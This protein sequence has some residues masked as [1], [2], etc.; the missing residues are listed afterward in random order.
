MQ[1]PEEIAA[2]LK[3][4]AI[5]NSKPLQGSWEDSNKVERTI[6]KNVCAILQAGSGIQVGRK[7]SEGV[8]WF[9]ITASERVSDIIVVLNKVNSVTILFSKKGKKE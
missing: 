2:L 1:K 7:F 6:P 5:L 3:P 9:R 8:Q 4:S